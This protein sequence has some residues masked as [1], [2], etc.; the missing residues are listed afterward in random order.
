MSQA[1]PVY[2]LR[3][4]GVSIS[5]AITVLQLQ[6][7]TAGPI[8]ILRAALTQQAVVTSTQVA[9]KLVRK[10]AAATVTIAVA[11]TNLNKNNPI[12]P[13]SNATLGTSA[14][15]FTASGEGTDG[16]IDIERGFNVLTGFEWLASDAEQIIVPA[17]GIFA[18]KFSVAPPAATW[19]GEIVF[20]EYRG[21]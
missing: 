16:E 11:G 4:N 6:A 18:L 8:E 14:T 20:R 9:A 3:N 21:S 15:G 5:T 19:Y 1:F 13:A 12:M 10:S 2:T 17:A 7:G